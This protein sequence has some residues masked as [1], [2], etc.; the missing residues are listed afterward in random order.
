MHH[1]D[2]N[3]SGKVGDW[4]SRGKLGWEPTGAGLKVCP[5]EVCP[6][7]VCPGD[8]RP[9]EGGRRWRWAAPARDAVRWKV[10]SRESPRLRHGDPAVPRSKES[11]AASRQRRSTALHVDRRARFRRLRPHRERTSGI[12]AVPAWCRMRLAAHRGDRCSAGSRWSTTIYALDVQSNGCHPIS[13][14]PAGRSSRVRHLPTNRR[15][16]R[17]S[18]PSRASTVRPVLAS[19]ANVDSRRSLPTR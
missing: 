2:P 15:A 8:V 19:C 17:R 3:A 6:G 1:V 14:T 11:Q 13:R 5:G 4:R 7:E 10:P 12:G 9:R 16:A 18:M